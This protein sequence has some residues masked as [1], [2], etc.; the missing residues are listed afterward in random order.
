MKLAGVLLL[1]FVAGA[2]GYYGASL[3]RR[4]LRQTAALLSFFAFLRGQ[5]EERHPYR[6]LL[7][8]YGEKGRGNDD[9]PLEECGF[10][11]CLREGRSLSEALFCCD[12]VGGQTIGLFQ[13]I[14]RALGEE[15]SEELRRRFPQWEQALSAIL[16]KLES[17][18]D[19]KQKASLTLGLCAG[20]LLA[21]L[22]W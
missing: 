5:V 14:E 15:S 1:L 8:Q 13:E 16:K 10:R 9:D 11:A 20:A 18:V 3:A 17:T 6:P 12:A 22:L 7:L 21:I 4:E 19:G 2:A